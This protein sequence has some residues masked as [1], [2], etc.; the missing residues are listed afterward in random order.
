MA[1]MI[2]CASVL[3]AQNC[4]DLHAADVYRVGRYLGAKSRGWSKGLT[5]QEA[6]AIHA[7]GMG[8]LPIWEGD[9]V[10][11]G[12]FTIHQGYLDA[13][14]ALEDALWLGIPDTVPIVATVDYDAQA[15]DMNAIRSYFLS[16]A[17]GLKGRRTGIYGGIMVVDNVAADVYWQ[18]LAWSN[19]QVSKRAHVYQHAV[20]QTVANVPV[21]LD[22]VFIDPGF[23]LPSAAKPTASAPTAS[24]PTT[25]AHTPSYDAGYTAGYNAA[26]AAAVK[27]LGGLKP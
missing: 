3:T 26:I 8:I 10:D 21:D 22:E 2:D 23:W 5:P 20:N 17:S 7:H 1:I 16:F 27:S 9:P 25:A 12:Y 13:Q 18:T 24:A 19:G 15:A 11:A 6:A 4:A 14:G